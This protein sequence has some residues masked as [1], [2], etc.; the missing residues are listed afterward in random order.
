MP[1]GVEI[2]STESEMTRTKWICMLSEAAPIFGAL[3]SL[4][5]VGIFLA[6]QDIW[7]DFASPEVW[8][9]AGHPIP[10]WYSP[11]NRC[12]LEWRVM[13]AGFILILL[14]HLL[15]ILRW[16][17]RQYDIEQTRHD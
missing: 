13:R 17:I 7:H 15:L 1:E 5:L 2:P 3:S 10:A 6:C 8:A 9:R 12:I 14:F 16:G 4:G 11:V